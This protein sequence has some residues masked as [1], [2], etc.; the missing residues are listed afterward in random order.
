MQQRKNTKPE[1][2]KENYTYIEKIKVIVWSRNWN[3]YLGR[4]EIRTD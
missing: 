4:L 2:N 1:N 3:D